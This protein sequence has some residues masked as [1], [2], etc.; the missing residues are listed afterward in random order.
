MKDVALRVKSG[1]VAVAVPTVVGCRYGDVDTPSI[2]THHRTYSQEFVSS[3]TMYL[4]NK[5]PTAVCGI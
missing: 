4:N 3:C 1:G 5:T 2:K